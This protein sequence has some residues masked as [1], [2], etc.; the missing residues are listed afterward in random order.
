MTREFE[1]PSATITHQISEDKE[2]KQPDQLSKKPKKDP[3][4]RKEIQIQ[5][6]QKTRQNEEESLKLFS[7]VE[8]EKNR[9]MNIEDLEEEPVKEEPSKREE[10]TFKARK[11]DHKNTT[12]M[13]RTSDREQQNAT[14]G[15]ATDSNLNKS[16]DIVLPDNSQGNMQSYA[17]EHAQ[18]KVNTS[19]EGQDQDPIDSPV[20]QED[21]E[22]FDNEGSYMTQKQPS[23]QPLNSSTSQSTRTQQQP[24]QPMQSQSSTHQNYTNANLEESKRST[25]S[26]S[27]NLEGISSDGTVLKI[28][29]IFREQGK[30]REIDFEYNLRNDTSEGVV[31]ELEAAFPISK[32]QRDKIRNDI[33]MIV[34]KAI[35][36]I[37][38]STG[39]SNG[40]HS[41]DSARSKGASDVSYTSTDNSH[42]YP[43]TKGSVD[44]S[45]ESHSSEHKKA[46]EKGQ[47]AINHFIGSVDQEISN[48]ARYQKD[49]EEL[50]T[51]SGSETT[52]LSLKFIK[53]VIDSY[54][55]FQYNLNKMRQSNKSKDRKSNASNA[56]TSSNAPTAP[57]M[58]SSKSFK[59]SA[60]QNSGMQMPLNTMIKTSSVT[61]PPSEHYGNYGGG[62]GYYPSQDYSK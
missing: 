50:N 59:N 13:I 21:Q 56:S 12:T 23:N 31:S 20:S 4:T 42:H 61:M 57:T 10:S 46:I 45:Q 32:S 33:D 47:Y 7:K 29:I 44:T 14:R 6:K 53:E 16:Q 17:E 3:A 41:K 54:R 15:Q 40:P 62:S 28:K 60:P 25:D 1:Q 43:S 19:F 11:D 52:S 37:R 27:L 30:N 49:I 22:Q 39:K 9:R 24:A 34:M 35:D 26:V 5:N 51:S 58:K 38:M 2:I 55:V 48:I 18:N 36:T 8:A